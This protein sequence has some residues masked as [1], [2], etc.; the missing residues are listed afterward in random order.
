MSV[1]LKN[2]PTSDELLCTGIPT[3]RNPLGTYRRPMPRVLGGSWGGGRF[4]MGE[5]PLYLSFSFLLSVRSQERDAHVYAHEER[6][7]L[8]RAF[9][10]IA[11]LY[12]GT[13]LSRNSPP[14]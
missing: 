9:M 12:R 6:A 11:T 13:S 2:E 8:G 7:R 3:L 4:L 1:R 14:P 10:Q 5:V